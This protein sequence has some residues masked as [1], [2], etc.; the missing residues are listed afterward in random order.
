M[1]V[2]PLFF[3]GTGMTGVRGSAHDVK[4]NLHRQN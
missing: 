4:K 1:L 2:S 3:E